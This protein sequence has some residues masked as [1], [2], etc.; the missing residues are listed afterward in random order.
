MITMSASSKK[1]LRR[2]E[3]AEL[4]TEK[5]RTERQEAKKLKLYT[6]VFA[7]VLALM[8]VFAAW[9]MISNGIENSGIRERSTVAVTIGDHDI[10]NAELNY[11]YIDAVNN[12][13]SNYGGYASMFGLD[14]T[15][16][17]DE[18]I[19]DEETGTTWADDFLSSA[20]DNATAVYA[21]ADEAK[22]QGFTLSEED[23]AAIET[24]MSYMTM[25][26][27]TYGYNNVDS[28]LK[29]MYGNGANEESLKAY[30]EL[31]YLADAFYNNYSESLT[32]TDAE[33]R[34]AEA[35]NFDLY[36]SFSYNYYYLTVS[37]FCQGGTTDSEGK[38]TYSDAE[39]AAAEAAALAA[40]EELVSGEYASVAD[41]NTA[42]A[43]LS[44]N[45]E[46]ENATSTACSNYAYSNINSLFQ[47]WV[48]DDSRT[49]GDMTY[50][51]NTSTSTDEA[52]N[53]QT[54]LNGYYVIY[55]G[56]SSDNSFPLANARHILVSFE[57]G[58]TDDNGVTTYSDE[59]KATAKKAAEELLAQWESGDATEESFAELANAESNDGDG[60][61]GGLYENI[62]PGQMVTNFNDWCFDNSRKTGDTGIVETEYGYHV[63]YYVGDSETTF[64]DYQITNNLITEDTGEWY[65]ALVDAME[66][67]EKDIKY[68]STDL[69]LSA[70]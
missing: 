4:L 68:I 61:T 47:D 15:K 41:F 53:E 5:Q 35:E 21:L 27:A 30:Y 32:Y 63:M 57:G 69:V 58:T 50:V 43:G 37:K 48:T 39:I 62:Y 24:N 23:L 11:F 8:V 67:T 18:Q 28:Y 17:L 29:A 51:A 56:S 31:T 60:T 16:P 12:F 40:A 45:A 7:V 9:T 6:T 33:L 55:F 19:V 36:S 52:G 2:A 22:A 59:E 49:A 20:I 14:L 65:A 34:A 25:Y 3:N 46:V 70:A 38:T 10:S 26:A 66:V 42:I 44:I 13:Y 64:R 54:T 1:K